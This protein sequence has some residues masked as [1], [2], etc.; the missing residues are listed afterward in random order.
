MTEIIKVEVEEALAQKFK[1][2]A[3]EKYGY[4]K[5]AIAKALKELI[6]KFSSPAGKADW[7]S[8][9]GK[10]DIKDISSVELQHKLWADVD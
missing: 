7:S 3:M 6:K 4:R 10:L 8:L 9:K 5:G 1:K 2:R